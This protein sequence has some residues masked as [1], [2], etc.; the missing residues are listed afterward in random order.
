MSN[1]FINIIIS[2]LIKRNRESVKS[3]FSENNMYTYNYVSLL[4]V[5]NLN[6]FLKIDN[7]G[8]RVNFE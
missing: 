8:W 5:I 7:V 3:K 6:I 2:S 4:F 1:M